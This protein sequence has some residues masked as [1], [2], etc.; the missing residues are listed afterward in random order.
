MERLLNEYEKNNSFR[1]PGNKYIY[2]IDFSFFYFYIMVY[3]LYTLTDFEGLE[4]D[5]D[6][7]LT[8]QVVFS[9]ASIIVFFLLT[10]LSI[11]NLQNYANILFFIVVGLLG[12]LFFTQPRLGVRRWFDLGPIDIQPSEFAKVI[13]VVFVA[14]YLSRNLNKGILIALIF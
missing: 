7:I 13:I 1:T 3:S 12:S 2:F 6:N 11:D 10:Y 8:R 5:V 4:F 9:I 14:N